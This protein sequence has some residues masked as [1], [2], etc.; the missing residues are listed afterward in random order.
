MLVAPRL[1]TVEEIG[2]SQG[3][4]GL[5]WRA[6]PSLGKPCSADGTRRPF[7]ESKREGRMDSRPT[8]VS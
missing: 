5:F 6:R 4:M 7:S 1:P 8:A 3:T 2:L